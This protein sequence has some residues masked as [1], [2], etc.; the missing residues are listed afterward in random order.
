MAGHAGDLSEREREV[1][2]LLLHGHDAKSIAREQG[3]SVNTVNERLRMSRRKLG[4][5][6]SREAARLLGAHEAGHPNSSGPKEIGVEPASSGGSDRGLPGH[7]AAD[8]HRPDSIKWIG[9]AMLAITVIGVVALALQQN[10][11]AASSRMPVGQP[12]VQTTSPKPGSVVVP[13]PFI[14]RVTF[15]RPM[16]A[17]NHSFVQT[18]ADTYPECSGQ[19]AMTP[20]RR[21][22]TLRCIVRP[23]R[24]YEVWLNRPPYMN[25]KSDAGVAAEPFQLLFRVRRR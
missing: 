22:F 6:S 3:L 4:V 1:L 16:R 13:G 25:F 7:R 8:A 15:D 14:L 10:G 18:S 21:T 17:G 20:D 24:S 11:D 23:G 19:P 5:S 2:R 12:R 9:P